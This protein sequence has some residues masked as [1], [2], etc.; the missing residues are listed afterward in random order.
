MTSRRRHP[1][2]TVYWARGLTVTLSLSL[3]TLSVVALPLT[4][5]AQARAGKVVGQP[6]FLLEQA[7]TRTPVDLARSPTLQRQV[8]LARSATRFGDAIDELSRQSGLAIVFSDDVVARD[9][10]VSLLG[11]IAS[12]AEV[13]THLLNDRGVDVVLRPN[14]SAALV[15]RPALPVGSV[16]GKVTEGRTDAPLVAVT[17]FIEGTAV[18]STTREDGTYRITQVPS[19]SRTVVARR[20]GYTL[21]RQT[22]DIVDGQ[23]STVDFALN[24]VAASLEAVVTT[25]TGQQRRIELGNT[26][27]TID[28]TSRV[29]AAPVKSIGELLN[30]QATGVHVQ[31]G[32]TTGATSRV[33]I[34]GLNSTALSNDPIW[35]I[36]GVRMTSTVGGAGTGGGTLP[37]RVNDIN[38]EEIESIE[39]VKGPSAATLYGTDAANGVIV[40]TTRRGKA[41]APIWSL[42]GERGMLDDRNDYLSQYSLLGKSPG[43]STQRRCFTNDLA[44]GS[45][46]LDSATVLDI[47]NSPELTPLKTSYRTLLGGS[48]SGGTDQI[49]YFL[50]GDGQQEDGPFGIPRFDERR[51][52]SLGVRI[53]DE[54]RRPSHREQLSFR[55][56]LNAAPTPRLD[57]AVS[58]GLTVGKTR[59]PQSDNNTDGF[60][61][62]AIAGPG[63]FQGPGY[64]GIGQV[65][66]K[67]FG[68]A[69]MTPGAI[70]Q[71]LSEQSVNRFI[72]SSTANFRP[73]GW[74]SLSGDVGLDLTDRRDYVLQRLGEGPTLGTSRQGEASD[75]RSRISNL[76]G[77]LRGTAT[78]ELRPWAQL[79]SSAGAQFVGFD[80]ST[81]SA[82]GSQLV[83]GGE[84]PS[85]GAVYSV[86]ANSSPSRTLGTYIE[87]QLALRD[88]LFLTAAVRT[89]R[90]SAFGVDYKSAY[91]PKA[92]VSWVLSEEEFFPKT[93]LLN[94][95]RL[96]ASMGSSGV[97]PGPTS[98]LRTYSASNVYF[99]GVTVAGLA[100][101]NPGNPGLK[102]ERSSELEAGFDSRWWD[103]RV[104]LELTY[105]RKRTTDALISQPVA[106]SAGIGGYLVNLG[107]MQNAGW[108]YRLQTQ[109]INARQVGWDVTFSGSTNHNKVTALGN[110]V[111]TPTSAIQ[112]GKPVYSVFQRKLSFEDA[113]GDG[114]LD[115]SEVVFG[116]PTELEYLGPRTAPTQLMLSTNVELFDRRLRLYA[117]LD[118]KTGGR[119]QNL[120]R[121][122]PCLVGT[123][124]P[125]LQRIDSPLFEQARGLGTRRGFFAGYSEDSDFTKLR[126]VSATYDLSALP[127]RNWFG[128]KTARVSVAARNLKTWSKWTG[129]DPEGF[130]SNNNDSPGASQNVLTVAAP[131]YFMV[132]LNVTY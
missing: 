113:N 126:E 95:L 16:T 1:S 125:E 66:E 47:W 52:D 70:F 112:V 55:A 105:Y 45:C 13:L 98:A 10:P 73:A 96:R 25:A 111:T 23:E 90:N 50:S 103:D 82:S 87:E 83:P 46:V 94:Q 38:P 31:I 124:C 69:Q 109:I 22:V 56:N 122:L 26:V 3:L 91:Y 74:F 29:E 34:R 32:T 39:V 78:W 48:V 6:R 49:R 80:I 11:R 4:L 97:Q 129:S 99:Q 64:T 58:S 60:V 7:D 62:N 59:F 88:R 72:G 5:G 9:A 24:A 8:T 20:V 128:A 81:T 84:A 93:S 14:G 37:S 19:G 132:R 68:Y 35:I 79:R 15:P 120:E 127:I 92:G 106:P 85:Q 65:G 86:S 43:S 27:A 57:L 21:E 28:V 117:L 44:A 36:D 107:G 101:S 76:T 104:N 116:P 67:L 110:I 41:G 30:A 2:G 115:F 130:I 75:S 118:R 63:Y 131:M 42:H 71:K 51:F 123:S 121:M 40:L 119:E 54:M 114:Y 12:V 53:T 89:D 61:Y 33:R 18:G 100:Q 17:V 108:E 77:N 102:P